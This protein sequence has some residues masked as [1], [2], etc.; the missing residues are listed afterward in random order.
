VLRGLLTTA[1]VLA[2]ASPTF[3]QPILSL[4]FGDRDGAGGPGLP[5]QPGFQSSVLDNSQ[6][7]TA[8][9]SN[10]TRTFG[11]L[12]V[13]VSATGTNT[14]GLDD[15]VRT[16]PTDSGPFTNSALLQDFIFAVHTGGTRVGTDEGLNV[17]LRGLTPN[18]AYSLRLWS[19]DNGSNPARVSDWF[20]NNGAAPVVAGYSFTGSVLPTDNN[21]DTF[22]FQASADTSGQLLISGRAEASVSGPGAT[23][24]TTFFSTACRSHRPRRRYR[25]RPRWPWSESLCPPHWLG[26]DDRLREH[27]HGALSIK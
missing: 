23:A 18:A 9:V 20:V 11:A 26:G 22:S 6:G 25:S 15:R 24:P 8:I 19:Y 12:S 16:V 2:L 17:L 5:L 3:A 10:T 14:A 27:G 13:T 7:N 21:S 4:D 1:T